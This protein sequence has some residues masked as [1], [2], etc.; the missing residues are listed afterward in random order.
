M[1]K[2]L[3]DSTL[4]EGEQTPGVAFS[5]GAK[6]RIIRL[7]AQVGIEEIELGIA[8]PRNRELAALLSFCRRSIS[9]IRLALWCRCVEQDIRHAAL[10]AP[11][12]LSLSIPVS[13]LHIA[14]KLGRDRHWVQATLQ[15]SIRLARSLGLPAISVGFEDATRAEPDFLLVLARC[16]QDAGAVRIRL[17]DTVGI[18]SP[19]AMQQMIAA[20]LAHTSLDIGVHTHN[21][22]GMA[23]ANAV[24][25]LEAGAHWA[26]ATVLGLGE[27]AGNCRLEEIAGYLALRAGKRPYRTSLFRPLCRFVAKE[28]GRSISASHP[29]IGEAIFTCETGLH[30][31]GLHRNPATYEPYDPG[32]VGGRRRLL[33][34]DKA[35]KRA[36]Y[37]KLVSLGIHVEENELE[38]ITASLRSQANMLRRALEDDEISR[39]GSL[40][41]AMEGNFVHSN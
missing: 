29:L 17:A 22:F 15:Q 19:S 40:P 18:A 33:L 26:D 27:R 16:A 3:I 39:I 12:V 24:A 23:T 32:L 10:L 38:R 25:A 20:L 9:G 14:D 41:P 5:P 11:D 30:L 6:E 36:V 34:G 28:S 8:T 4:R 2:G 1:M 13:D 35:G 21:D 7:L 37:D 31:Q